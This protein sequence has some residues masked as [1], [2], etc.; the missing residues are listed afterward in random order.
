MSRQL[1][2]S[3]LAVNSS[4]VQRFKLFNSVVASNRAFRFELGI[5]L[6]Q[7]YRLLD[8]LQDVRNFGCA[9]ACICSSD[10]A[11]PV[12]FCPYCFNTFSFD[13]LALGLGVSYAFSSALIASS[14]GA[15]IARTRSFRASPN[16]LP[17]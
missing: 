14:I 9:A 7:D 1:G 13:T 2:G 5:F 17:G 16:S 3:F 11:E 8:A 4:P 12:D 10:G 15:S 6:W